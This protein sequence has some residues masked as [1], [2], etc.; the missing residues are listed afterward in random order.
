M[1]KTSPA[2]GAARGSIGSTG[3]VCPSLHCRSSQTPH[4]AIEVFFRLLGGDFP[5]TAVMLPLL[6][7]GRVVHILYVDN[8]PRQITQPDIGELL[9]LSQSVARSYEAMMS[10][11]RAG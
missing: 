5:T 2:C 4:L 3:A 9:I 6:V 1:P 8:G 10:A 11:R 7:R